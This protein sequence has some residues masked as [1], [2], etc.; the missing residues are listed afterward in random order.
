[1]HGKIGIT[2]KRGRNIK[3]GEKATKEKKTR[4]WN[5]NLNKENIYKTFGKFHFN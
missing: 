5:S 4:L 2:F 1:M 3:K